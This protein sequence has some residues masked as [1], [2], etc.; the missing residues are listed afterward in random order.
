VDIPKKP[1]V[2]AAKFSTSSG[3]K[4]IAVI[5]SE[6]QL[7]DKA[8]DYA[9]TQGLMDLQSM[10]VQAVKQMMHVLLDR[11]KVKSRMTLGLKRLITKPIVNGERK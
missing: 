8:Y 1:K 11:T 9:R 4:P 5:P 2:S 10:I 6:L 3:L 7:L